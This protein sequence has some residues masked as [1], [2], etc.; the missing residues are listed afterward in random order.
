MIVSAELQE[1]ANVILEKW[2]N[3]LDPLRQLTAK[4]IMDAG[5]FDILIRMN[6]PKFPKDELIKLINEY[7]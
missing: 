1:R 6:Y 2:Y 3:N 4:T 5:R 7:Q